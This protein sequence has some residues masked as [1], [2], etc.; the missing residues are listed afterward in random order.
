MKQEIYC[1]EVC[2]AVPK[3]PVDCRTADKIGS[4]TVKKVT[5]GGGGGNVGGCRRGK[6]LR[7]FGVNV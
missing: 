7:I 5:W 4:C 1:P 6:N 2:K 3:H